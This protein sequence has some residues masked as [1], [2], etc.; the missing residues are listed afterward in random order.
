MKIVC[1]VTGP[2]KVRLQDATIR[3]VK[4]GNTINVSETDWASLSHTGN[5]D[6]FTEPKSI[7]EVPAEK[8]VAGKKEITKTGKG[9][10]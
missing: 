4:R 3:K 10:K 6:I 9:G 8:P 7:Q 1:T 2:V 5:F